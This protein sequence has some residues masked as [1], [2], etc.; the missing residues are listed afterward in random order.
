MS[1]FLHVCYHWARAHGEG[2]RGG[3]RVSHSCQ[4]CSVYLSN[5][6]LTLSYAGVTGCT[7]TGSNCTLP[8]PSQCS[9]PGTLF[10]I[11]NSF[12]HPPSRPFPVCGWYSATGNL[13]GQMSIF[14][15]PVR[16]HRNLVAIHRSL[17]PGEPFQ[18]FLK[19][20][21]HVRAGLSLLPFRFIL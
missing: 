20:G 7:P 9:H 10:A 17:F 16:I 14:L 1:S 18:C 13:A 15:A 5:S 4:C 12:L 6:H 21:M 3:E 2:L 11:L 19:Q 8:S